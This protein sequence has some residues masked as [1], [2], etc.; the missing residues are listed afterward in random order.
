MDGRAIEKA[1]L[2][3]VRA[4]RVE[5]WGLGGSAGLAMDLAHA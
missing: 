1:A 3:L 5:V 4:G 2:A